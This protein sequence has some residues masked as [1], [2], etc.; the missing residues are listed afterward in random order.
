MSSLSN[1][2]VVL[3]GASRGIGRSTAV[4]LAR[5]GARLALISRDQGALEELSSEVTQAGGQALV[6]PADLGEVAAIPD[7]AEA[8]LR[9]LGPIDALINNAGTFLEKDFIKTTDRE[10]RHVL[11][12]NLLAPFALTRALLP[13]LR[14]SRGQV[15]N[16]ASTSALQ[17]YPQQSGY[18]ASKAALLGMMR[19]L[20]LEEKPH[21]VRIHTLCP[22]GVDTAFIEG[23]Q[24]GQRLAGQVMISP[25]NIAET[26][27][28]LLCQPGNVDLAELVIRRFT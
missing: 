11:D 12:V 17:G 10:L 2:T 18:C 1:K 6:T 13:A 3:T 15:I 28:F 24:L 8:L 14:Q 27:V 19:A 16:V 25:D 22:G 5:A 9:E 4:T 23:T 21:G 26:I 20:A 7:L